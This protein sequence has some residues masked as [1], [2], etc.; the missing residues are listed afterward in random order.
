M[1]SLYVWEVCER[2]ASIAEARRQSFSRPHRQ[3]F[4]RNPFH[5]RIPSRVLSVHCGRG[6]FA[7]GV[8]DVQGVRALHSVPHVLY[9]DSPVA[10]DVYTRLKS[11]QN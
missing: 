10:G 6:A 2:A 3:Y 7:G 4:A 11:F 9:D 1:R 5:H 8:G